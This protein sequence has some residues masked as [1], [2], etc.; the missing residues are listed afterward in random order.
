MDKSSPKL[1]ES[2]RSAEAAVQDMLKWGDITLKNIRAAQSSVKLM[3]KGGAEAK[4]AFPKVETSVSSVFK[5]AKLG[6]KHSTRIDVT[7]REAE[8]VFKFLKAEV[9][10]SK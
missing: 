9:K 7:L 4:K 10:A 6:D 8:A 3:T 5:F 2:L 1:M